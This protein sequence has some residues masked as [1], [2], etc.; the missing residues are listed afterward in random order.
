MNAFLVTNIIYPLLIVIT[1]GIAIYVL[2][3]SKY[4][5]ENEDLIQIDKIITNYPEIKMLLKKNNIIKSIDLLLIEFMTKYSLD[6][7]TVYKENEQFYSK[8]LRKNTA[9]GIELVNDSVMPIDPFPFN[10]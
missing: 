10:S 6:Y 9:K 1:V 5:A 8:H 7:L 4:G 3:K 2:R